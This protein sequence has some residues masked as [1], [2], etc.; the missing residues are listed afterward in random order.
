MVSSHVMNTESCCR[1]L[2]S[3]AV[4]VSLVKQLTVN[5]IIFV[6]AV[7]HTMVSPFV[8]DLDLLDLGL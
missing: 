6:Q 3:L 7:C 2:C 8:S 1:H 5:T 4:S